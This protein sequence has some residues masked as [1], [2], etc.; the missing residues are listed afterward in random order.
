METEHLCMVIDECRRMTLITSIVINPSGDVEAVEVLLTSVC[1][2]HGYTAQ[3]S[4]E[5]SLI[6][7]MVVE[8]AGDVVGEVQPFTL[9]CNLVVLIESQMF[10]ISS[11]L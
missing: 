2:G 5:H 1:G 11:H 7:G 3:M 8:V 4:F 10:I 9:N 6:P